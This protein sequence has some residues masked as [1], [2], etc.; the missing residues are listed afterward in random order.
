M[1]TLLKRSGSSWIL[2]TLI[3]LLGSTGAIKAQLVTN[4]SFESSNTGVVSGTDVKGWLI[5]VA[6]GV[7]PPPL[8]EIVSDTVEQGNRALKVTVNGLGTNQWDIQAVADS[9]P[10]VQGATYNY[11][12]WAK[13]R[14]PGAQVNFTM[15]NYAFTEY[16]A[17]RPANLTTQW[18]KF[19]MQFTVNDNQTFI[20]GPI[21]FNYAADTGNVIYIDNLQ[22]VDA[23]AGKKPVIVEAESGNLGS[24][25][26]VLQD[27]SVNYIST[28][29]NWTSLTSP[30]DT[31]RVATYQVAFQDSGFYN[32]FVRLRVGS[33]GYDD[34]SFF[35]AHGFGAK[36]DTASADWIFIN[37]LAAAGFSDSSAVVDGPGS[38]G[39]Q[40]WK[41]VNVTKNSYQGAPG[42][43]F[44]VSIDNLTRTFQIG[45][46]ENGL[47]FDKI[48]FGKSNLYFTVGALDK[49]L[50]GTPTKPGTGGTVWTGPA[51]AAGQPKF[52][53]CSYGSSD[54][55]FLNYWNQITPENAGKWGSVAIS[56][57]SSQWSWGGLDAAYNLAISNHIPFKDHNLIWGAQQPTWITGSGLDSAHQANAVEQW[58]RMVGTR[59]PR[60]TMIDVVNEPLAGHNPA[61]YR[62]ALGGS[63]TTGWD[64]VIWAFQK[65]RQYMPSTKLLL[66]EYG[67]INDNSSTTSYLQIINLL[68]ARN[69]IDGIGVQGH[70][71]ELEG[72]DTTTMKNNLDRLAAT[73][74]PIYISEFDLGNPGNSG[75][76]DDTQQLQLY[77][78]IFPVLWRH[79]GVKGITLWGY[80][81][82]LTWQTTCYLVR[83]DGTARPALL[84]LAQFVKD[85]PVGVEET[86]SRLP[87]S[88]QLEQNFPNPFN[89]ATTIRYSI[90]KASKVELRVFDLLGREVQTLVNTLQAPGQYTATLNAQD[91]ASGVYFY[92]LTAGAFTETKKLMLLK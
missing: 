39:N 37:G 92:R 43:S 68:K 38:L 63:G 60:M 87:S 90:A 16:R 61:P 69:L 46:R 13:A 53:G 30:G 72:A 21:H 48:A 27:G 50:A 76:P 77:Q 52:I 66:N 24:H 80:L 81:E 54:P 65:A 84:W 78:K 3:V 56:A 64:W 75:T 58:I 19:T 79:P 85:N 74:L 32:L 25:F 33:G 47:D 88:Y 55:N 9:I 12:I 28:D 4:G 45:S 26:K 15:G 6:S 44:Y 82:G 35:Y 17:I 83:S 89:P 40:V 73:G 57:D 29:T 7:N 71:F 31:S 18:Q 42:D 59:Y 20:R 91:L 11:S 2:L 8:I 67:I 22:I 10:V 14:K 34:D 62:A 70:R 23:N 86:A 1:Y 36:N 51:I 41:W 5:Q 49:G